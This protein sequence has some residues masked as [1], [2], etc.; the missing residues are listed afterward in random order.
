MSKCFLAGALIG[1]LLL[2]PGLVIVRETQRASV[3]GTAIQLSERQFPSLYKAAFH[4]V[5]TGNNDVVEIGNQGYD[6]KKN[7]DAVTGLGSPNAA[8]LEPLLAAFTFGSDCNN[9]S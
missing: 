2:L 4:D 6:A 9:G 7:W 1:L 5:T 3:R 8:N